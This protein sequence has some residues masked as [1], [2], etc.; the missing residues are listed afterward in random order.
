MSFAAAP[1]VAVAVVA[2]TEEE[3]RAGCTGDGSSRYSGGSG[4]PFAM[5]IVRRYVVAFSLTWFKACMTLS[6]SSC[7]CQCID[8]EGSG[9][10]K[11]VLTLVSVVAAIDGRV[12]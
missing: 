10:G 6:N 8:M 3:V 2:V 7:R 12:A 9:T 11:A 5:A 1:A 4:N